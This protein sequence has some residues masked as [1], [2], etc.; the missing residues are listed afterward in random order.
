MSLGCHWR[1]FMSKKVVE[2][3][4]GAV[5][6][7]QDPPLTD[8]L[9]ALSH[10]S[11]FEGP[12]ARAARAGTSPPLAALPSL[13]SLLKDADRDIR[14]R[15]VTA[16]G[17]LAAEVRRVLPALRAALGEAALRDGDDG[18]R[19]EAVRALLCAGP[20]PATEVA[21]LIDALRSPVDV[22]R[23]H[24]AI[25]LGESGP[26]GRPAVPALIHASLWEEDPAVRVGAA[27][28]LW[29]IDR[30]GPLVRYVL[31][32][33]LRDTN[34]LIC[35]IAAEGLGQMGAEA[36]EA[37]PALRQALQRDFKVS[38]I[39]TAVRLALERIDPQSL[40]GAGPPG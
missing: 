29:K 39:R 19:A 35:W 13:L 23:F 18:V 1:Y 25:A 38:L 3:R 33:A 20:Q 8:W 24:A 36:Q 5:R 40:V 11:P 37:V 32:E 10:D 34:E 17:D 26:D 28:A 14:L 12:E 31:T 22:V 30:R 15:A 27:T 2:R 6:L 21:G 9:V 4:S 7:V 16:L